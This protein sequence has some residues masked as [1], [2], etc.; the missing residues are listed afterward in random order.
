MLTADMLENSAFFALYSPNGR[1]VFLRALAAASRDDLL[2]LLRLGISD[3]GLDSETMEGFEDPSYSPA[4]YYAINCSDYREADEDSEAVA[5]AILADAAA[6]AATNPRLLRTYFGERL[7]CALWP[8][9]GDVQRPEPFAGGD[10]PT[11]VLNSDTD[12]ITPVT[13]A[14]SVLYNVRNGHMVVMQGGPHVTY[15]WGNACPD[16]IVSDMIL[17]GE[18]PAQQ[19]QLCDWWGGLVEGYVP[20]TL[21]DAAERADA[22]AIARG[23]EIELL[24]YPEMSNWD[25][26]NPITM[27]CNHGGV[28]GQFETDYGYEYSFADC[29]FWPGITLN[30]KGEEFWGDEGMESLTLTLTITGPKSGEVVY[31]SDTMAESWAISGMW[32]GKAIETPR[33]MP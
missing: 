5:R 27:G 3:A 29:R 13:Q 15:G 7:V 20:L 14:Y 8:H 22:L 4:S 16:Q 10:Y 31:V 30:G 12:P 9:D 11:L 18:M 33:P 25:A 32:D 23:V 19:V 2:P 26:F 1:A 17:R 28:M 6:Y 21:I 24:E